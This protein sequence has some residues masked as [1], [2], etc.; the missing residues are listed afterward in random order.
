MQNA[1]FLN[2]RKNVALHEAAHF[3]V[4][5]LGGGENRPISISME[6]NVGV[7]NFEHACYRR[8]KGT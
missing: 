1:S 6:K 8:K 2:W 3:V 4:G 5:L 7:K